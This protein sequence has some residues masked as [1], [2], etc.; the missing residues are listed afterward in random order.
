M[1][2][3]KQFK[4]SPRHE[5][6]GVTLDFGDGG[7]WKIARAG[8]SNKTYLKAIEKLSRK[9]GRQIELGCLPESKASALMISIYAESVVLGFEG[10]TDE[11]GQPLPYSKENVIKVLTDLPDFFMA[12]KREA[13]NLA[14]FREEIDTEDAKN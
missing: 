14:L 12:I 4:M 13:T 2:L 10:V 7:K 5:T 9:Y 6:E 1:S 8:G 11:S 3:Y